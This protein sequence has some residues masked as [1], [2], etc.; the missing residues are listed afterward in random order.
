MAELRAA[1]AAPRFGSVE[2]IAGNEF[3]ARV[4]DASDA[5]WVVCLLYKPSHTGCA[6]LGECLDEL[7]RAYPAT[8]FVRIISTSCIPNYPD[9]NLPTILLYHERACVK[10][11]VG[12]AQFGGP[13][14]TPEQVAL[15]LNAFG[16]VC[17]AEGEDEAA[18]AHKQVKGLVQRML[19]ERERE[20]RGGGGAAGGDESSDFG[21][22]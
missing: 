14:A 7:A 9:A 17:A 13:R 12:L 18:A 4:T 10:S 19:A 15:A 8:S 11:L 21:D 22:D 3:V 5:A 16:P 6:L 1:A 2:E 20:Q